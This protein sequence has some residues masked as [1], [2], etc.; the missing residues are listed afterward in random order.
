MNSLC[1]FGWKHNLVII[2][3]ICGACQCSL[4]RN[5][6]T[7]LP[8]PVVRT[9]GSCSRTSYYCELCFKLYHFVSCT[10]P[11]RETQLSCALLPAPHLHRWLPTVQEYARTHT[12]P[13][14][15][16]TLSNSFHATPYTHGAFVPT[17]PVVT[18]TLTGSTRCVPNR[19]KVGIFR[20]ELPP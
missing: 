15:S 10:A 4:L 7:R 6:P 1:A 14:Y 17:C 16:H 13:V 5:P 12:C 9:F 3:S 20:H 19:A 2:Y 18:Y 8:S 11:P